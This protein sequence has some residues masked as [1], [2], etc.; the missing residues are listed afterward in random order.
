MAG[1]FQAG[2][3]ALQA[4]G[5]FVPGTA[6][7]LL[8]LVIAAWVLT[9]ASAT[10]AKSSETAGEYQVK[11]AFLYNFA[12]FVEWPDPAS[13][14]IRLCIVGDDPF[15]SNLEVTV[16]GKTISGH[17]IEI[18]RMN[19]GD[20]PRDCQIAFIRATER[21]ARSVLELLQGASTLTVGESPNFARDG[22]MINFVLEDKRV[23]FEINPGAAQRAR[24]KISSR[25][26]SLARIVGN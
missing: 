23:H 12:K 24:L 14:P 4:I 11:A 13:G 17:P 6:R 25:L 26:L 1:E 20:N 2:R 5:S 7:S 15:G 16:R 18:R 21:E 22:G 3:G 10:A 9:W 19:R 8:T